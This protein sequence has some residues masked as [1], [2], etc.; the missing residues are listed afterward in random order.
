MLR[1]GARKMLT[2]VIE[3]EVSTFI[4]RQEFLETVEDESAVARND[5]L[6]KRSI[7]TGL[8]D[9]EVKVPKIRDRSNSGINYLLIA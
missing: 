9:I 2:A 5:Y 8:G 1:E 6:P 7:Q 3:A 4:E